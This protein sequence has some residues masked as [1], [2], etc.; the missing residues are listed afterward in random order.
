MLKK[1][2]GQPWR[3]Y[4]RNFVA[5]SKYNLHIIAAC[6]AVA[7][8]GLISFQFYWINN[9]ISLG[10]ERFRQEALEAM[11]AVA[12]QLE[13]NEV[14]D[15]AVNNFK[16]KFSFT[17]L[18]DVN[19]DSVEYIES[20]FEKK[21]LPRS[22]IILDEGDEQP[23]VRLHFETDM[24]NNII[25]VEVKNELEG[26]MREQEDIL[27]YGDSLRVVEMKIAELNQ[28]NRKITENIK[29]VVRK[30]EM[31]NTVLYELLMHEKALGERVPMEAL[32]GL[33][34][35]EFANRGIDLN[36]EYAIADAEGRVSMRLASY[37][38]DLFQDNATYEV[39]LFPNDILDTSA[40][41][42]VYFYDQQGFLFRQIWVSLFASVLLI[43]TILFCFVF[44]LQTIRKQKKLSEI[45]N[46]FI[47]NMTHEFKTPISTVS[48]ATEA[49]QDPDISSHNDFRQ[50]YLKIISEENNRLG[51]QVEKVLQIATLDKKDFKLKL[52]K[53]NVHEVLQQALA[54]IDLQVQK[55]GGVLDTNLAA[56]ASVVVADKLHLSNILYNLLDNANKYSPEAPHITVNTKSTK[57]GI[58]INIVDRGI[59]ISREAVSRIFDKFYRVPTGNLHDVKGFGLGLAYVK[60]MVEAHGGLIKVQSEPRRGSNFEVY[61][62]FEYGKA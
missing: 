21:V 19:E 56:A 45:K 40:K 54:N 33:L 57:T 39:N 28:Q 9:A 1:V 6:M 32:R 26:R 41:L 20:S 8:V 53:V 48:L 55:R 52:D 14:R 44:S 51:M 59:G 50:R 27:V 23:E 11:N 25:G 47:N 29:K 42:K 15:V 36:Y 12:M 46:D 24:A 34:D 30:S 10:K 3:P 37:N 61:I 13:R 58:V 7:L 62:P 16:S 2:K 38:E 22:F 49:L 35:A 4:S 17:G 18:V 31:V 43:A 5:M 60:M